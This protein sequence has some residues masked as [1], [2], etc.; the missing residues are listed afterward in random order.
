[1]LIKEVFS[2][3]FSVAKYLSAFQNCQNAAAVTCLCLSKLEVGTF[4]FIINT[5]WTEA[6][7]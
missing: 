2:S 3:F 7:D 4:I 6:R 1:M 5:K